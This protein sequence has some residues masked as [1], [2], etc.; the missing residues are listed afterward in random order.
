MLVLMSFAISFSVKAN[1][2]FKC[3]DGLGLGICADKVEETLKKMGCDIQTEA[4]ECFFG[5]VDDPNSDELDV[6]IQTDTP[7]CNVESSNCSH[8]P[9]M[10]FTIVESCPESMKKIKI[11]KNSEVTNNYSKGVSLSYSRVVCKSKNKE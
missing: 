8:A 10:M 2:Q 7:L 9:D 6:N 11:P 5:L 4:T 3:K 1:L